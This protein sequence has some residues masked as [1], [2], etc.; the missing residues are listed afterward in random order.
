MRLLCALLAALLLCVGVAVGQTALF[1]FCD[2]LAARAEALCFADPDTAAFREEADSIASSFFARRSLL[3]LAVN[4]ATLCELQRLFD[5]ISHLLSVRDLLPL[6]ETLSDLACSLRE[7]S[8]TH[9]PTVGNI[10]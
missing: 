4:D 1:R 7:I 2:E 8:R 10:L 6:C 5:R 9:L 3:S